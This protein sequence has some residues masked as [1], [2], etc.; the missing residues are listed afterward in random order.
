MWLDKK[1]GAPA[2]P[3]AKNIV[4]HRLLRATSQSAQEFGGCRRG[5]SASIEQRNF[6]LARRKRVVDHGQVSDHDAEEREAHA[7]FH[8]GKSACGSIVRRDIAI[9]Q[10]EKRLAAQVE[11][12]PKRDFLVAQGSD[13]RPNR[14]AR[15]QTQ[16]SVQRPKN[17]SEESATAAQS[18]RENPR[19]ARWT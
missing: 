1:V 9:A 15:R 14:T 4:E 6:S 18:K 12:F 5:P 3:V 17:P 2:L 7:R 11:H 19:A 10:R 8:H 16:R 13:V